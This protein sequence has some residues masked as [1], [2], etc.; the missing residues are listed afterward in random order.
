MDDNSV[1]DHP[2][3]GVSF[4]KAVNNITTGYGAHFGNLEGFTDLGTSQDLFCKYR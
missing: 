3:L 1:P 2:H 4:D